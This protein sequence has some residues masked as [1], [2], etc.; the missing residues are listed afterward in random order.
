MHSPYRVVGGDRQTDSRE[1]VDVGSVAR[2]AREAALS[3]RQVPAYRPGGTLG[4][5]LRVRFR[6][7][8]PTFLLSGVGLG[9]PTDVKRAVCELTAIFFP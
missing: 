3:S 9:L 8:D 1:R 4:G 2:L 7:N 5:D 6:H